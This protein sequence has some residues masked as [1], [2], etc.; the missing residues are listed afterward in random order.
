MKKDQGDAGE[1][2]RNTSPQKQEVV[3]TKKTGPQGHKGKGMKGLGKF[4]LKRTGRRKRA[5]LLGKGEEGCT[6]N[7]L[8]AGRLGIKKHGR[9][10]LEVLLEEPL[11]YLNGRGK[12]K[13]RPTKETVNSG[14]KF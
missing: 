3:L 8:P 1:G 10:G 9:G 4:Q 7:F 2:K 6:R 14:D 12:G 11:L 13:A 5:S